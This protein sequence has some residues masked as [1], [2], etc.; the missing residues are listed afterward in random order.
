M[1]PRRALPARADHTASMLRKQR[2]AFAGHP[3][4]THGVT[5]PCAPA[6][7][8]SP[9][10][11]RRNPFPGA[12]GRVKRRLRRRAPDRD[13]AEMRSEEQTSERKSLMRISYADYCLKK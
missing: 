1:T 3:T 8:M 5:G 11:C 9:C 12:R 4:S 6:F 13:S 10:D 7:A 2:D